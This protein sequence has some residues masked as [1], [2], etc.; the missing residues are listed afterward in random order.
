MIS[1]R[2]EI[3]SKEPEF[4]SGDS[5]M[6]S[7]G[8]TPTTS[9]ISRY[10]LHRIQDFLKRQQRGNVYLRRIRFNIYGARSGQHFPKHCVSSDQILEA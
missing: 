7:R 4:H 10:I 8:D 6:T 2:S 1:L 3:R 5:L 9:A